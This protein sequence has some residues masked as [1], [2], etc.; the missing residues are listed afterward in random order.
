[1]RQMRQNTALAAVILL[2]L[3]VAFAGCGSES[4]A[5][6]PPSTPANPAAVLSS[7]SPSSVVAGGKGVPLTVNGS[8]FSS[9]TTVVWNGQPVPATFL[10][11]QQVTATISATLIAVPGLASV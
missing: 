7:L 4:K 2:S 8:N 11:S 10:N 9:S 3:A 5:V 1:M 6:S